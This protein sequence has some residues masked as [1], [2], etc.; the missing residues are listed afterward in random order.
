MKAVKINIIA[1][2]SYG[3]SIAARASGSRNKT[4]G[5]VPADERADE[6]AEQHNGDEYRRHVD[7]T[8]LP[9]FAPHRP[10]ERRGVRVSV[11]GVADPGRFRR[12]V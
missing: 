11:A 8:V 6:E 7:R 3:T 10:V 2:M 1:A 9:K 5:G 12:S 4:A